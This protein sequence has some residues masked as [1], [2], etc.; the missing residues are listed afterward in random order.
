MLVSSLVV[1][2]GALTAVCVMVI[3]PLLI[4]R[5]QM[6]VVIDTGRT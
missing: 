5:G 2:P 4:L 3:V 6:G 1:V